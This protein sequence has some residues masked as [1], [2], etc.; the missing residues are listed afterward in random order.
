MVKDPVF[1]GMLLRKRVRLEGPLTDP[2]ISQT[3]V[4][5]LTPL[6]KYSLM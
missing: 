1:D 2:S 6:A 3:P 5:E 4:T